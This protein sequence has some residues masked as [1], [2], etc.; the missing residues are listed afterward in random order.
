[1]LVVFLVCTARAAQD[2][3][4]KAQLTAAK[5]DFEKDMAAAHSAL[6]TLL[7]DKEAGAQKAGNLTLLE[8]VR[9]E[10]T[11]FESNDELPKSVSTRTYTEANKKARANLEDAYLAARKAY[12]QAGQIDDANAVDQ[13]L[14]AF[15]ITGQIYKTLPE[16]KIGQQ[17]DN[18]IPIDAVAFEGH[19]YKYFADKSTWHVAR[20]K[21]EKM[22][23]H[24]ICIGN[25]REDSFA[26]QL[27]DRAH[28][29]G[30]WIGATDEEVEGKWLWVNGEPF[31][32]T[33]W[34][35]RQPDNTNGVE[36]VG[37]ILYGTWNDMVEG[38]RQGFLCEWDR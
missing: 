21:C 25:A 22:G 14:Q 32:Y 6:A 15:R 3:P 12:T 28:A 11:A 19:H 10:Q 5:Q 18:E 4:I 17:T 34:G 20:A 33:H 9:A 23:G 16:S 26:V 8:K 37:E 27:I 7:T 38:K 13:E 1:L 29:S 36:D 2:D 24:L 31:Y 35:P 30:A